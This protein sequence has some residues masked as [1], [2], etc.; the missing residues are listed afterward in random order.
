MLGDVNA[1]KGVTMK[2]IAGIEKKLSDRL[3]AALV[4]IYSGNVGPSADATTLNELD[5]L[6]ME[7]MENARDWEVRI[8][9]QP[10]AQP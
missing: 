7:C 4:M 3:T 8:R 10:R 6:G 5:K 1:I 2:Q 9:L